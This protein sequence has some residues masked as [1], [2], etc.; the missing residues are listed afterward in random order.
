MKLCLILYN[1][2]NT[3]FL[4]TKIRQ[5]KSA[6]YET[7]QQSLTTCKQSTPVKAHLTAARLPEEKLTI[8][9]VFLKIFSSYLS[10]ILEAQY[11]NSLSR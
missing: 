5:Y 8:L 9:Y 3:N 4:N 6:Q 2:K 7:Q 10:A 11:K 1:Q